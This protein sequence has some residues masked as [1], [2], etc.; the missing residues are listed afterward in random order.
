LRALAPHEQRATHVE[1]PAPW[2]GAGLPRFLWILTLLCAG[3]SCAPALPPCSSAAGIL[4]PRE[5]RT[6]QKEWTVL[7]Y[8]QAQNDLAPYAYWDLYEMEATAPG[9]PEGAAS[10]PRVDVIAQMDV[11][12]SPAARRLHV[13]PG[14]RPWRRLRHED[15]EGAAGQSFESP[16]LAVLPSGPTMSEARRLEEFLDWGIAGYPARHYLVVLWGHGKGYAGGV[17][18]NEVSRSSIDIPSLARILARVA[19]RLGRPVD[20]LAQDACLMQTVEVLTEIGEGAR[21]AVGSTQTQGFLGLPYRAMMR[22]LNTGRLGA[23]GTSR[24]EPLGLARALA[25]LMQQSF[26]PQ[27]GLRPFDQVGAA[28]LTLSSVD[29]QKLRTA[30][31]PALHALGAALARYLVENPERAFDLR[32]VLGKTPSFSGDT[33]DLGVFLRVLTK[34]RTDEVEH[35]GAS[36]SAALA[37]DAAIRDSQIALESS[38]VGYV[39][40]RQFE[41]PEF[42]WALGPPPARSLGAWI[43]Y[44]PEDYQARLPLFQSSRFFL[45]SGGHWGRW[46]R[47]LFH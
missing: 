45:A 47:L 14:T 26:D 21:F 36:S 37:L 40:G 28:Y 1:G 4:K 31:V 9:E 22:A 17:A 8:L 24:D 29:L 44:R 12:G 38:L 32:H 10:S 11:R 27:A 18:H 43:P 25:R 42:T 15:L 2:R 16:V 19:K 23:D 20:I 30:L 41:A 7:I 5:R 6:C 33:Q 13:L 34:V 35:R 46:L 39:F 3:P